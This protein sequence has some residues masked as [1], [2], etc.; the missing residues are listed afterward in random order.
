M[1]AEFI[2]DYC[3]YV[4]PQLTETKAHLLACSVCE[5]LK[6]RRGFHTRYSW[7]WLISCQMVKW[8]MNDEL[9][10]IGR[11]C[12]SPSANVWRDHR[13]PWKMSVYPWL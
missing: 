7:K 11:K 4:F 10:M 5:M 13:K 2:R 12:S 1:V 9:E 6:I 8:F 3:H